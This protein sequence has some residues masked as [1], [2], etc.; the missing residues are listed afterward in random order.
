MSNGALFKLIDHSSGKDN[1]PDLKSQMLQHIKDAMRDPSTPFTV[2]MPDSRPITGDDHELFR[3]L[4]ARSHSEQPVERCKK[5]IFEQLGHLLD[6]CR[7][8]L[9]KKSG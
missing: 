8:F 9:I 5:F 4:I 3:I 7:E 2:G 6:K 1:R